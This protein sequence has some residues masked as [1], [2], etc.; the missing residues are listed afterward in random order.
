MYNNAVFP[1]ESNPSERY[2]TS[3]MIDYNE[4]IAKSATPQANSFRKASDNMFINGRKS[5]KKLYTNN[6]F[7]DTGARSLITGSADK[8]NGRPPSGLQRGK[9]RAGGGDYQ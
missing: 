6:A 5:G 8:E 9:R 7:V 1:E 4:Q 2:K 3:K